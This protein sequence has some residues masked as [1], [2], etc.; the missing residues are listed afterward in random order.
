MTYSDD[1]MTSFPRRFLGGHDE[2]ID[3]D[4]AIRQTDSDAALARLSAVQKQY[5]QDPFLKHLLPRG[6]QYQPPRPP[7]I[8]IG[9]YVRSQ[10]IDSLVNQWLALSA[11]EGK[12]C[13]IVSLGAGS[14]TRFW[15][16]AAGPQTEILEKYV[17][18][19]FTENTTKKAMA[20]RKSRDLSALLGKPEDVTLI[21]AG[22]GLSSPVYHLLA[23]DL[24]SPS[25]GSLA[26][27]FQAGESNA[28]PLLDISLPTLLLFECVLVYMTPAQSFSLVQWFVDHFSQGGRRTMLGGIVYEMF[29][30]SDSFGKVMLAN[31]KTR[32]V[33]LPGAEPYPTFAS[34]PSRFRQH[35]FE[36]SHAITL[37]D[38]R[39]NCIEPIEYERISQLELLDEM[40]EL[41]LVLAHYAITWGCKTF[42]DSEQTMDWSTWGLWPRGI[43]S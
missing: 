31:L 32:H 16:I 20:I 21:N 24:R 22:T 8:N 10:G 39:R 19:D 26:Q 41:E 18:I 40:E 1:R 13:Q 11:Q 30:L 5:L 15:R 2:R 38:Y 6:S 14:D 42:G 33:E 23:A 34:L 36:H 17:E 7:L 4:G 29:G 37:R 28:P 3:T 27:L 35:G 12:K 43:T 25:T 9:T